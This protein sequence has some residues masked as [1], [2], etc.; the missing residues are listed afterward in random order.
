MNEFKIFGVRLPSSSAA[1]VTMQDPWHI[2][3]L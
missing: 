1:E 2:Q 3:L